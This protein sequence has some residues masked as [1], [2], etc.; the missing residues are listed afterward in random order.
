MESK[1]RQTAG[2][3]LQFRLIISYFVIIGVVLVLLNL[4]PTLTSQRATFQSKQGQLTETVSMYSSNLGG[5]T[6]LTQNNVGQVVEQLNQSGDAYVLVLDPSA[7]AL[8]TSP[9]MEKAFEQADFAEQIDDALSGKDVFLCKYESGAF[10]SYAF[11]PIMR[12]SEVVGAVCVCEWDV[13]KGAQFSSLVNTLQTI[14]W[15]IILAAAVGSVLSSH[16]LTKRVEKLL[17]AVQ[18]MSEGKYTTRLMVKGNDELSTLTR[19]FNELMM[20]LD[21]AD[22]SQKR[23]VADASHELKTPLASIRL[24]ADSLLQNENID[25]ETE[26]EF[27]MDIDTEVDRLSRITEELL[28]LTRLEGNQEVRAETLDVW[29]TVAEVF[30]T[31]EPQA[32]KAGVRLES[33]QDRMVVVQCNGDDLFLILKNLVENGIKYNV[34]GGFVRVTLGNEQGRAVLLV[35]DSGIGIPEEL[36]PKIFDRFYRIDKA[37]SREGGGTGLGLSIVWNAV[38]RWNGTIRVGSRKEGGTWFRVEFPRPSEVPV[39]AEKNA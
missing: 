25:P 19:E 34:S 5:L 16:A 27:L 3:S 12:R 23:F 22:Q 6:Q 28:I 32:Q 14:S 37:R 31:L 18:L 10:Y 24:L 13:E 1:S 38:S 15:I 7:E 21:D 9:G 17:E 26:R 39:L 36:Q 8:Y 20:R 11:Q 29:D 30:R 35:E 4:Y 33:N 2:L